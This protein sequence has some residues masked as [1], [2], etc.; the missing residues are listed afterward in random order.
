MET[1]DGNCFDSDLWQELR[2]E[3][4]RGRSTGQAGA[5]MP[6]SVGV[7][8]IRLLRE[9]RAGFET[10][11]RGVIQALKRINRFRLWLWE[12]P[13]FY[14]LRGRSFQ[15]KERV[16]GYP[17]L[18]R[19]FYKR[20]GYSLSL[21]APATFHHKLTWLKI[22]R[23]PKLFVPAVDKS[24]AKELAVAWAQQLGLPLTAA[25]TLAVVDDPDCI[26]W[27][28]LPD[29]F[30]LKATHRSGA[31]RFIDQRDGV[32]R[33]ALAQL[34]RQWLDYPYGVYKH[35]W[36]YWKVPRRLLIEEVIEPVDGSELLD[37]KFH[38]SRGTCLAIQVNSGFQSG[39]RKIC[40]LSPA[41]DELDVEWLY[42]RPE[43]K[44]DAPRNLGAMLELAKAFSR[45]FPYIRVGLY[46]LGRDTTRVLFGEFTFY[47]GSG[48]VRLNPYAFDV[49]LGRGI[50]L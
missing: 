14:E 3:L 27:D 8:M 40:L 2:V 18:H 22:Q 17:A 24:T 48:G 23:P 26:P 12:T 50:E 42:P 34:C 11:F 36:A 25:K 47:P 31:N 46:S 21:S 20:P 33:V 38:M 32:D 5:S 30:V 39:D 19:E 29:R 45:D 4:C 7:V 13:F 43:N 16:R 37:Y 28:A 35:E 41:W 49:E 44:P 15:L 9:L 1:H 10:L 6:G